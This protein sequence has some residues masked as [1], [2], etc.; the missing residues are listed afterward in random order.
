MMGR[1]PGWIR[2]WKASNTGLD[3]I[4]NLGSWDLGG[5]VEFTNRPEGGAR[6]A[7]IFPV[8]T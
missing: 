4:L 1:L 5:Q 8:A 7:V 6:V 2:P 3:L